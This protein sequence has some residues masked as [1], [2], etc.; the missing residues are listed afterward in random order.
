MAM[1]SELGIRVYGI[2]RCAPLCLAP[3]PFSKRDTIGREH[4][5]ASEVTLAFPRILTSPD[6]PAP[7][8]L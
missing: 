8:A 5:R 4:S 3:T 6:P 2:L 7:P 1:L